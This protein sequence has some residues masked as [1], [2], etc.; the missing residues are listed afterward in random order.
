[1][2][3]GGDNEVSDEELRGRTV[4]GSDRVWKS[5]FFFFLF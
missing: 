1:M 4:S 2:G 5:V 3:G